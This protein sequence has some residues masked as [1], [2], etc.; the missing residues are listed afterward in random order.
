MPAIATAISAAAT[1]FSASGVGVFLT[2]HVVGRLIS[3]AVLSSLARALTPKAQSPGIVTEYTQT[4]ATSPLSFVLGTYA[5]A[6][7]AVCPPM[8]H[9]TAGKTPNAYRNYVI[10][11]GD[12]DRMAVTGYLINGERVTLGTVAHPDYGLP[13]L[14]KYEG[15][16]WLKVLD[17]TQTVADPMLI[18]KYGAAAERPWQADMIGT[19]VTMC[20][21]TFRLN[22]ELFSSDPTVL[23]EISGIPLYDP[24]LDST[25]G[26]S[27]AQRWTNR[28]TWAPTNNPFVQIYNVMRGITIPGLGVWGGEAAAEDLP[29]SNW[30]ACMN[31]CDASVTHDTGVVEP[32]FRS[33]IEVKV[34]VEPA[35]I[36]MELLKACTG[37]LAEV[38]G[39]WKGR[40]GA[41]GL[42]VYFLTDS[43][44]IVTKGGSRDPHKPIKDRFNAV[45]ATAHLIRPSAGSRARPPW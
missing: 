36:I 15:Y 10:T 18:A 24:R 4:G 3:A 35:T 25:V 22:R 19:G 38:G 37:Q 40:V 11:L 29:L 13:V 7:D 16:A 43:D 5:T 26:G 23:F 27:G 17:G 44:I 2:Q 14:G 30:F 33:G 1:A 21:C 9:G 39:V 8:S 12:I 41:P 32:A 42:P 28:A 45:M 6:G 31:A 34:D 20:I